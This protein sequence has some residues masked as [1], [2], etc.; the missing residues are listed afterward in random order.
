MKEG[1]VGL[2]NQQEDASRP[3]VAHGMLFGY[4]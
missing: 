4:G 3:I 2:R 1:D